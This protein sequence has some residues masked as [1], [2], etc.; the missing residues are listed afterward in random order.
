M[1]KHARH[2]PSALA[3]LSK[4][5]FFK[6]NDSDN[7]A[8]DE[9]TLLH[10]AMET[11]TYTGLNTEQS[12]AIEKCLGYIMSIKQGT[13]E[14]WLDIKE[15][16]L[17]LEERTY[18]H[19]DRVLI[20]PEKGIVHVIDY[21]FI[22][23]EGDYQLQVDT[24]T[25]A[26]LESIR[27]RRVL[28]DDEGNVIIDLNEA[29]PDVFEITHLETHLL[30][31]RLSDVESEIIDN[32][33]EF[34]TK[35]TNHIDALYEKF[36]SPFNP[37]TPHE[38][39]C[40]K[41][42]R[43]G[44]CPALNTSVMES[45]RRMY[46]EEAAEMLPAE[47]DPSA[48]NDPLD[49][50]RALVLASSFENWAKQIK[51]AAMLFVNSNE[52]DDVIPMYRTVRRSTGLS[53]SSEDLPEALDRLEAAGQNRELALANCKLTLGKYANA[54]MEETE[55][56]KQDAQEFIKETLGDLLHEGSS[57][58]LQKR[59]RLSDYAMLKELSNGNA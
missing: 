14:E 48:L 40:N 16:R 10:S 9:G 22:R 38:D 34:Y 31:P 29:L 2:S 20:H 58:Y 33:Y 56:S 23:V 5:Q 18:G 19:A 27:D 36:Q 7:A 4:C 44:E 53:L 17:H 50:A 59:K 41:C 52:D 42:A 3:S 45:Y 13:D 57:E 35:V 8:A 25:A 12:E 37:P 24:Y 11:G 43:A 47:F 54:L 46:K 6:Y 55:M 26:M 49:W 15:P 28:K 32:P 39:L 30:A 1:A 21:K 51:K